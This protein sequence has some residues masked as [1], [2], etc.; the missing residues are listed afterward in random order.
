MEADA[1]VDGPLTGAGLQTTRA[2]CLFTG[3]RFESRR[4]ER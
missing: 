4:L 3:L 1:D 2:A